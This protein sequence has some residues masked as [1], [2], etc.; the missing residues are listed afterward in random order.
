LSQSVPVPQRPTDY[1]ARLMGAAPRP[2]LTAQRRVTPQALNVAPDLL[3]RPRPRRRGEAG[4]VAVDLA[5]VAVISTAACL[6]SWRRS[7]A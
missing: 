5:L 1:D 3:G 7:A 2:S 4:G 6:V